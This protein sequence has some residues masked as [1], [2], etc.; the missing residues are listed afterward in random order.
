MSFLLN[1]YLSGILPAQY[2]RFQVSSINGGG[3]DSYVQLDEFLLLSGAS[4]VTGGTYTNVGGTGSPGAEGPTLAGDQNLSTKWLGFDGAT[5]GLYITYSTAQI[6]TGYRIATANDATWRDPSG[7]VLSAS[8][9]NVNWNVIAT[10]TG[11]TLTS[12]RNTYMSDYTLDI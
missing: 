8:K 7:W 2:F 9:N 11:V 4:V 12:S 10:K 3:G 5:A 6:I 1:P